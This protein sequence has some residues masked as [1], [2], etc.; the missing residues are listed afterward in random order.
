MATASETPF[1]PSSA[2]HL[3]RK[4]GEGL[5]NHRQPPTWFVWWITSDSNGAIP[6]VNLS[7]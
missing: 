2:G 7:G 3:A 5:S 6:S 4:N 1:A